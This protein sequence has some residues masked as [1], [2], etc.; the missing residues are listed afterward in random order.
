MGYSMGYL[1]EIFG[2][3]IAS[4]TLPPAKRFLI[5]E[6]DAKDIGEFPLEFFWKAAESPKYYIDHLLHG[7]LPMDHTLFTKCKMASS[8]F[9]LWLAVVKSNGLAIIAA[10]DYP[11]KRRGRYDHVFF[12]Y[13]YNH[14]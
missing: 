6:A 13:L 9:T 1:I 12:I 10:S 5:V 2:R 8:T 3:H 4:S 7:H 14:L 11:S